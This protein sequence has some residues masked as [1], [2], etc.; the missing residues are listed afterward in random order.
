M[1]SRIPLSR[2]SVWPDS[3]RTYS[4]SANSFFILLSLFDICALSIR[5]C[6]RLPVEGLWPPRA[7]AHSPD[8]L[9]AVLDGGSVDFPVGVQW[10]FLHWH[11]VRGQH[12]GG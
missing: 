8:P 2:S 12:V 10:K 6:C 1:E 7:H 9:E 3:K 11:P 5:I 4:F